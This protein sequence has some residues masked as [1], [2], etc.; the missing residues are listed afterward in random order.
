MEDQAR[1]VFMY[2]DGGL[3][4]EPTISHAAAYMEPIDVENGEYEA[5]FDD[6]GR[7]YEWNVVD[8]ATRLEPTIE[9]DLNGLMERLREDPS[10]RS[11]VGPDLKHPLQAAA[12]IS[13]WEWEHRWPRWPRWLN[14]R[15]HGDHPRILK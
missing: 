12:A 5:V 10:V 4:V 7:R 3:H 15:L 9:F 8:G 1:A 11:L 13:R 14:R 2:G 6:S